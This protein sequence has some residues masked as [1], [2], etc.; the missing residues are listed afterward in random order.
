MVPFSYL[1]PVCNSDR[2]IL[3]APNIQ[4]YQ[5]AGIG[6]KLSSFRKGYLHDTPLPSFMGFNRIIPR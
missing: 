4:L 3:N 5:R 6:G 2:T 1:R